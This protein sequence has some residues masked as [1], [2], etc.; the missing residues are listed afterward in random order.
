MRG[1]APATLSEPAE[2]VRVRPCGAKWWRLSSLRV[3]TGLACS[4]AGRFSIPRRLSGSLTPCR[5][6]LQTDSAPTSMSTNSETDTRPGRRHMT[7]G[8][9]LAVEQAAVSAALDGIPAGRALDVACGTG[10]LTR[11][12]LDRGHIVQG[13][14][15]SEEMLAHARRN[16]PAAEYGVA[17]LNELPFDD[18]TW[19]LV[20]CGLALTHVSSLEPAIAEFSRVLRHG[21]QLVISDV[22]PVAV[23]TGAHAFFRNPDGSRCVIRN[24]QH[25]HGEYMDAFAN[26]GLRVTRC[27][28]PRFTEQVLEAFMDND[29]RGVPA[30][31][32]LVGLPYALVWQC[33][34][35]ENAHRD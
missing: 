35:D 5:P 17:T 32:H 21:G 9:L 19:D 30:L 33:T 22:H 4:E 1:T 23:A 2:R 10:R 27:L 34:P 11:L 3:C 18:R 26:A 20:V 12:L 31:K 15:D 29:K 13:V 25:W 16:A 28:E 24:E 14:D 7:C 6:K 8:P